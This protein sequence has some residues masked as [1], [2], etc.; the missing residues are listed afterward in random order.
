MKKFYALAFYLLA[1]CS[2]NAQVP[3]TLLKDLNTTPG[4]GGTYPREI[5][6]MN[7]TLYFAGDGLWKSNGTASGT[8]RVREIINNDG[9][10]E[11]IFLSPGETLLFFLA[12]SKD[13]LQLWNSDGSSNGTK[14]IKSGLDNSFTRIDTIVTVKNTAFLFVRFD[15]K[16]ELWQSDGTTAGTKVV[17]QITLNSDFS[18]LAWAKT[19]LVVLNESVYFTAYDDAGVGSLWRS[20]GTDSGTA[21]VKEAVKA[22][23]LKAF[24]NALFFR[25]SGSRLWRTDGTTAGT[26]VFSFTPG[27]GP[28]SPEKFTAVGNILYFIS[29]SELWKT[30]GT[31]LGTVQVKTGLSNYGSLCAVGPNL[32][33]LADDGSHG[34]E[35]WR[36]DGTTP[37][38]TMAY[39]TQLGIFSS[40]LKTLTAANGQLFFIA[41][42]IRTLKKLNGSTAVEIVGEGVN[43]P[44]V[45]FTF[46]N[47][48]Y[49]S[50][51]RIKAGTTTHYPELWRSDGTEA[52]TYTLTGTETTTMPSLTNTFTTISNKLYFIAYTSENVWDLFNT[53]GTPA[54]TKYIAKS[55]G[56]SI[57]PLGNTS[58]VLF[59]NNDELWKTD[60]TEA[61]SVLIKDFRPG[62]D[63]NPITN[64]INIGTNTYFNAIDGVVGNELWKTDGTTVGTVI[65]KDINPG[66][67]SSS[68]QYSTSF[69]GQLF[70]AANDGIHGN[71]LWKTDGTAVGTSMV[72]DIITGM[73]GSNPRFF[74]AT[75]NFLYFSAY[76]PSI[77]YQL[78]KSDGT[79]VGTSIVK[80]IPNQIIWVYTSLNNIVYFAASAADTGLEL[81]RSDGS[82]AG[83]YR[84][85]DINPGPESSNIITILVLD[86]MLFF[87]ANDGI[88]GDELWKSDGTEEGT[89]LIQ[90]IRNG[91]Y[92]SEIQSFDVINNKLYFIAKDDAHGFE[93][94][95]TDTNDCGAQRV[96]DNS[97]LIPLRL[98]HVGQR[99]IVT[100]KGETYGEEL[101][102]YDVSNNPPEKLSQSI[103][104][105][106]PPEV[107]YGDVIELT[108]SA[109][110][111]VPVEFTSSD[112]AIG[113]LNGTTLTIK[114]LGSVTV[115][116]EHQ[117]DNLYCPAEPVTHIINV[118]KALQSIEFED[119]PGGIP[120][121]Q[122]SLTA[123]ASSGLP[124]EFSSV[125]DKISL[126]D[127][128]IQLIHAGPVTVVGR[129]EGSNYYLPAT[130]VEKSFCINPP[131][132]IIALEDPDEYTLVS[133]ND[134]GNRWYK[135]GI[136]IDS[137][138]TFVAVSTGTYSAMTSIEGC[139]SEMSNA[140]EVVILAIEDEVSDIRTF[141][142]P[143][144]DWLTI[145][146]PPNST[147]IQLFNAVGQLKD[148]PN[149]KGET[150][151]IDTKALPVGIYFL[152]IRTKSG[153]R[154]KKLIKE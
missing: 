117:G 103:T 64:L 83:T 78:W 146:V 135:D 126:I 98:S 128:I 66:P 106:L 21:L 75:D 105:D 50:A 67:T 116:A 92:S 107:R 143:F 154:I 33:F 136:L 152:K 96:T 138:R 22:E 4:K 147:R 36:S 144:H 70:F 93:V 31:V 30:D 111:A 134:I 52:G 81:W 28:F 59:G 89:I 104:F 45:L 80:V 55:T 39:E 65:V 151:T 16:V 20:N 91:K 1:C 76:Q 72:K 139:T 35:V 71:E 23:E 90:D 17:K 13:G 12:R 10:I 97:D 69:K 32:F 140:I 44:S 54:G 62:V 109:S 129:Q 145:D 37:G 150:I 11:P 27:I 43:D 56:P 149:P 101:Y 73:T 84:V 77:G 51:W 121:E 24:N 58:T 48:L 14:A 68:I 7:G 79:D 123:T 85:K 25:E 148:H 82:E 6:S 41:S 42:D 53:D 74:V 38:T 88:H 26:D 102:Y 100:A 118:S 108:A 86:G 142:N 15:K 47:I 124:V 61:G 34:R 3:L 46:N 99:L 94:W 19:K 122:L 125:S 137:G 9:P 18:S 5:V 8:T 40:P 2:L 132:P 95:K 110:S 112:E 131:N 115:T 120:G 29:G 57:A 49:F 141:P 114:D 133:T 113:S 63:A 60:G 87:R 119:I 127:N 153:D 130:P